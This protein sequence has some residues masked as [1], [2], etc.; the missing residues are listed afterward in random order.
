MSLLQQGEAASPWP[1]QRARL[2][3]KPR[4]KR[5]QELGDFSEA[6]V[7]CRSL[8]PGCLLLGVTHLRLRLL[9][10]LSRLCRFSDNAAMSSLFMANLS[11]DQCQRLSGFPAQGALCTHT[12][13]VVLSLFSFH[14]RSSEVKLLHTAAV[15]QRFSGLFPG[16]HAPLF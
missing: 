6:P 14:C 10:S 4:E 15:E 11:S 1:G 5:G 12:R 13:E 7:P 2:C 8:R 16:A 9:H 3:W